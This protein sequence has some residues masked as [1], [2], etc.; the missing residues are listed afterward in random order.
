M[1][2]N[3]PNRSPGSIDVEFVDIE[4]TYNDIITN[5]LDYP[6]EGVNNQ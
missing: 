1:F 3:T 4:K 5:L 6:G 2:K